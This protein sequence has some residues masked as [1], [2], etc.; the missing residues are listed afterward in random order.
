MQN[1]MEA[2]LAQLSLKS[3]GLKSNMPSS[4]SAR[5]FSAPLNRQS[6]ALDTGN[7]FLSPDAAAMGSPS[8]H[9]AATTL[10]QQ[11]AKLK[12]SN[13]AHRISAPVLATGGGDNRST[14]GSQLGQVAEQSNQSGVQELTVPSTN[15]RPK[16]TEFSGT[17]GS[18]RPSALEGTLSPM[19]GDSWASMVNTP[20]NLMFGQETRSPPQNLD[21]AATQ[22][23]DWS[24]QGNSR[25]PLMDDP[26]K[27]RRVSKNS[28]ENT[29][30]NQGNGGVYDN[31]GNLVGPPGVQQQHQQQQQ[32]QQQVPQQQRRNVSGNA[33]FSGQ[34][35]WAGATA[36]GARSPAL[37]NAS[38]NRFGTDDGGLGMQGMG[39]NGFNLG[40]G[41]PGLGMGMPGMGGLAG[42]NPL[43][44]NMLAQMNAMNMAGGMPGGMS[45]E[46][47]LLAAQLAASGFAGNQW[48]GVQQQMQGSNGRR[49]PGSA[50]SPAGGSANKASSASGRGGGDK[51]DEEEVDPALLNDVP[52]WL[53]TLR[54]HKYTPNFEGMKWQ[55]MVVMD[56]AAL[57]A[58][59]V[60]ALGARRKMLK[61]FEL[62]RAKMGIDMPG[63]SA[64]NSS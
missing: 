26:K 49:G 13:A 29:G 19:G 62:V 47:Q 9:D 24:G 35:G 42:M 6:L 40:L 22:L 12:A 37:S 60:A 17:L 34:G 43:Q 63:D 2:K 28:A 44:M 16:S 59:G 56:E 50:R 27:F 14:W 23:N 20:L 38:S 8:G 33:G 52:N 53:R 4:P 61:T 36:Q 31:D 25:V 5:N 58:N 51:K 64:T 46:A 3:P 10:A 11:R 45:P 41:S 39:M 32:Q 57:E 15:T 7:N 48:M 30:S 54:L 1:Q 21:A 18:G 55:D